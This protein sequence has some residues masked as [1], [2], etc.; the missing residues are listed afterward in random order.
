[1]IRRVFWISVGVGAT[2]YVLQKVNRVNS[3]A[4]HLTPGGMASAVNNLAGAMRTATSEFK[5]SMAE[6][7]EA[8]TEALLTDRRSAGGRHR[9]PVDTEWD[10]EFVFGEDDPE[11]YL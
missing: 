3:V 5:A 4:A 6:H 10:G 1:M 8:L 7:E 2:I 9:R 11:E